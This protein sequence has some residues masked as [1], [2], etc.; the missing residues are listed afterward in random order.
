MLLLGGQDRIDFA[1]ELGPNLVLMLIKIDLQ[2]LDPFL[3]FFEDLFD[4]LLLLGGQAQF[5]GPSLQRRG[6]RTA[7]PPGLRSF[8]EKQPLAKDPGGNAG[9]EDDDK[10]KNNPKAEFFHGRHLLVGSFSS[11][12]KMIIMFLFSSLV[13]SKSDLASARGFVFRRR[14]A[15]DWLKSSS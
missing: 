5:L 7:R 6:V 9:R 2:V 10:R 13:S 11:E 4:P 15:S 12:A 14:R 8:G 1:L 3:I